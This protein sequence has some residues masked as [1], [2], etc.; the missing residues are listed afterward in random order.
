M[1]QF[2]G[3]LVFVSVIDVDEASQPNNSFCHTI[4]S[5]GNNLRYCNITTTWKP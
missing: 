5:N 1:K 3:A 4:K 2:V